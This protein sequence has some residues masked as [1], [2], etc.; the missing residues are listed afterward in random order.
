MNTLCRIHSSNCLIGRPLLLL[1][2]SLCHSHNAVQAAKTVKGILN[3]LTPEA[4]EKLLEQL[5]AQITTPEILHASITLVFESAVAQPTFVSMYAELCVR[6]SKVRHRDA[7]LEMP[8]FWHM[9]DTAGLQAAVLLQQGSVS[10]GWPLSCRSRLQSCSSWLQSCRTSC[11][12]LLLPGQL[13]V[14]P[15]C[16]DCRSCRTWTSQAGRASSSGCCSTP[17]RR[18]SRALRR[19]ARCAFGCIAGLV[20]CVML[21]AVGT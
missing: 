18:S 12:L 7:V 5:K 14:S 20:S 13:G 19:L 21:E 4:F 2:P 17:A 16:A 11:K 6:L 10:L 9:R 1:L 8:G 15:S 3:K